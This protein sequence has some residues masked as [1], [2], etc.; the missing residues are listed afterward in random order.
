MGSMVDIQQLQQQLRLSRQD[1]EVA[2]TQEANWRRRYETEAE[3]RRR[4]ALLAQQAIAQLEAKL[5]QGQTTTELES[6]DQDTL[7]AIQQ[8]VNAI[9]DVE[10]LRTQLQ[11]ALVEREQLRRSLRLEQASHAHTRQSLTT[12]LGEAI[13]TLTQAEPPSGHHRPPQEV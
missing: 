5:A 10:V 2:Q 1:L 13:D 9:A 4:D 11:A 3:Q 6:L 12:A 8:Q 7:A